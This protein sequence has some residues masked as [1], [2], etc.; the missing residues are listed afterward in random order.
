MEYMQFKCER[1]WLNTH[2]RT[3]KYSFTVI[4]VLNHKLLHQV[5][6]HSSILRVVVANNR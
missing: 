3:F 5:L 6:L 1:A 2:K 4:A